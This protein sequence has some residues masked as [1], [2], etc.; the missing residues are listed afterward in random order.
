LEVEGEFEIRGSEGIPESTELEAS[1][2]EVA[3]DY[4]AR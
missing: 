3:E 1:E 4:R 2:E